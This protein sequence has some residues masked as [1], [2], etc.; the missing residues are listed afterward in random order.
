[1]LLNE[2]DDASESPREFRRRNAQ[3]RYASPAEHCIP[4]FVR[5]RIVAHIVSYAVD[6][7]AELCRRTVE[8]EHIRRHGVLPPELDP[9]RP[10]SEHRPQSR[11]GRTQD[12]SQSPSPGDPRLR[13]A[14]HLV[15]G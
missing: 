6:L 1:M 2:R 7:D 12:T 9:R 8:V 13:R 11:L 4:Q 10:R 5:R 3:Y 15:A 14:A